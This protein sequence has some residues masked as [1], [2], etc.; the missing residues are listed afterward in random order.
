MKFYMLAFL[1]KRKNKRQEDKGTYLIK[2]GIIIML[3][4]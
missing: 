1:E 3:A 2:K 4:T